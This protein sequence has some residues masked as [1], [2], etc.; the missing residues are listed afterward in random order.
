MTANDWYGMLGMGTG[1]IIILIAI[2]LIVLIVQL[3]KTHQLKTKTALEI[4]RDEAYRKLSEE[5][6]Q[7]QKAAAKLV[8]EMKADLDKVKS[9]VAS[10]H[11]M[12]KEVESA[13]YS[14]KVIRFSFLISKDNYLGSLNP[15]GLQEGIRYFL[16][17]VPKILSFLF[18]FLVNDE[19]SQTLE[20][21]VEGQLCYFQEYSYP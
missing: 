19:Q 13:F 2:L 6:H 4:S 11:E 12:M 20:Q 10:M 7:T 8:K 3:F 1:M 18:Q 14:L 15:I 16:K 17:C 21:S 9:Q 5:M